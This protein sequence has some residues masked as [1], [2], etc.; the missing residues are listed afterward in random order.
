[1]AVKRA[2]DAAFFCLA[3]GHRTTARLNI[4]TKMILLGHGQVYFGGAKGSVLVRFLHTADLHLGKRL[5]GVELLEDQVFVLEQIADMARDEGAECV[6][7]AGDIYQSPAAQD[8]AMAAFDDFVTRLAERGIKVFAIGGNHDSHRKVSYLSKL[9]ASWGVHLA[10]E[11]DGVLQQVVLEDEHGEIVVSLLPFV[12]P[13]GVRQ[14]LQRDDIGDYSQAVAAALG[15]RPID[16]A[17]RNVLVCHQF[18]TGGEISE[19]EEFAVGGMDN[20]NRSVFEGFD[21]VALGHLH[22]PQR[23]GDDNIR[24]SGSI[25]KYSFSEAAHTKSCTLVEMGA[26]GEV[27]HKTLPIKPLRDLREVSG[28]FDEIMAMPVTDDYMGV[29]IFDEL[30]PPDA[31]IELTAVFPNLLRWGVQNSKTTAAVDIIAG[32]DAQNKSARELFCDFYRLV[33][34]DVPPSPEH[35]KVLDEALE[36][37]REVLYE[38]D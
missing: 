21:Y 28:L 7:I 4:C 37:A 30:V 26:K 10:Q 16:T 32:D 1:M 6:L 33:N 31:Q 12:K 9:A 35:L 29:T 20:V 11:F 8:R 25:L 13:G 17:K 36:A 19:S 14:K 5:N 3:R 22:K 18:V 24:Y 2:A 27:A 23:A 34:S 15:K 38:A